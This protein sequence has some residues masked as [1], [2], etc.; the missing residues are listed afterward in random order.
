MAHLPVDFRSVKT[1]RCGFSVY[2]LCCDKL[3]KQKTRSK[4]KTKTCLK[5]INSVK[6]WCRDPA[7]YF[8]KNI[9][10]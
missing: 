1:Y 7:M 8:V 6:N 10:T 9:V 2:F 3:V 4:T 5:R